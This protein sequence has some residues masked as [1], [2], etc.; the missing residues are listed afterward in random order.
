MSEL[1]TPKAVVEITPVVVANL[2]RRAALRDVIEIPGASHAIALSQ[3][4]VTARVILEAARR[5]WRDT[6]LGVAP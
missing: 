6:A 1:I 5:L 3:P 4:Q 2:E